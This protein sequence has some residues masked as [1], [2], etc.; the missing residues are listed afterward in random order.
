MY[1]PK[2]FEETNREKLADLI[3]Q[4]PLATLI[5]KSGDELEVNHI[6]LDLDMNLGKLG[7]L[8]GHIARQN[9]MV[10]L[11]QSSME[12]WVLFHA[13]QHYISANWYMEKQEHHRVV[14]TWNYRVVHVKGKISLKED[15]K[16]LR[17]VL[18]KL[19][20]TQEATQ[21]HPWRMSDAPDDFIAQQLEK[22]VAFEIEIESMLGKFKLSQNRSDADAQNIAVQLEHC[23][24]DAMAQLIRVNHPSGNE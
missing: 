1:L 3:Q 19:T 9:P 13:E 24:Q 6:P 15:P 12:V 16:Y 7:V 2:H 17:G 10:D 5:L 18:A 4:F 11:I 21:A 8:K 23:G 20:R 14:P 22:I